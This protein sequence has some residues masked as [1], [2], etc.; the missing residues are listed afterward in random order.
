MSRKQASRLC[1]SGKRSL[2]N[3]PCATYEVPS[4]LDKTSCARRADGV[5]CRECPRGQKQRSRGDAGT[6][7]APIR[8]WAPIQTEREYGRVSEVPRPP[9][10]CLRPRPRRNRP[11]PSF[12]PC[13]ALA[14]LCASLR[15]QTSCPLS[16]IGPAICYPVQVSQGQEAEVQKYYGTYRPYFVCTVVHVALPG[17]RDACAFWLCA[18]APRGWNART[19]YRLRPAKTRAAHERGLP[20]WAHMG[21]IPRASARRASARAQT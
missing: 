18:R 13:S 19:P 8:A 6:L 10:L 7:G 1:E 14:C 4:T 3:T 20:F 9:L 21:D 12:A 11:R 2:L 16:A 17:T 15:L 5:L